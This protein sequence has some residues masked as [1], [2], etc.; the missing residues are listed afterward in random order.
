MKKILYTLL[1][2]SVLALAGCFDIKDEVFL[3]EKGG[4]SFQSTFD[5]SGMKDMLNMLQT[6]MPDSLKN[7]EQGKMLGD[8]SM[9]DSIMSMWK[10]L[11]KIPGISQVK[12]EKK[13]D[14]IFS[15]SFRF[16][17]IK[18]LNAAMA[19]RSRQ[20]SGSTVPKGDFF[21][22]SKGSFA[23]IDTTMSALGDAMKGLT[24][25]GDEQDSTAMNMDMLKA[26]MGD[27]KYTHIYHL[28]GKVQSVTNKQAK[29]SEDG[30]T[31]TL[32]L[33]LASGDKT[34]SLQNII[35]FR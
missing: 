23:C 29:I 7:T 25:S 16:A 13:G 5:M 4:G 19:A 3:D 12:K 8:E 9:Q 2:G 34:Q 15:I 14:M 28:P 30:K 22:Y 27:M 20:D 18:A 6:M 10:D 24:G 35:K 11:E 26:F 17:D 21:Q 32:E 1:V 31:V 33:D